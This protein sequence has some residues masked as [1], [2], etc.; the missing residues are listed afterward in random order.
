MRLSESKSELLTFIKEKHEKLSAVVMP[1][2]FYD[3]LLSIKSD[4]TE[5]FS[6]IQNV[7]G[8]KGGSIDGI[9]QME[10]RG[11]NAVNTASALASLGVNVTPIICS[12]KTG[13]QQLKSYLGDN[14]I[15]F[16]HIKIVKHASLTTALEFK[17][18]FGK[19]NVMLRELGSL[20]NFGP[21]DL[22]DNDYEAIEKADYVCVFNWAGTKNFGTALAKN[23]FSRIRTKGRGKTYYDTADPTPNKDKIP[24]LIKNVLKTKLIDVLSVNENEAIN[25]ASIFESEIFSGQKKQSL[26]TV[27]IKAARVLAKHLTARIDLHTTSFSA[28]ITK[29][30]EVIVPSFKINTLRATGAGD[31]WNAGNIFGDGFGLSDPYRLTLANAVS[32]YYLS[33]ANGKHPTPKQLCKFIEKS[34]FNILVI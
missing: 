34:D 30:H 19:V 22:T 6:L 23:V 2:F 21:L 25:Y 20:S 26:D 28:T 14:R 29:Q 18:K 3:R 8:R 4:P 27:A 7:A 16:S 31:T 24:E 12:N 17:T 13:F 10:I 32:A 15:N 11:G 33:N 5:F 1:D 9:S